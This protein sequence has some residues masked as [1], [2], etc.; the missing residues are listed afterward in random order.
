M[1]SIW[2]KYDAPQNGL[3]EQDDYELGSTF[4]AIVVVTSFA[5]ESAIRDNAE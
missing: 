1:Y 4:G 3:A 5:L 2:K